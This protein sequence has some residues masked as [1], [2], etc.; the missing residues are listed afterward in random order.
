VLGG[1]SPRRRR[2]DPE[3]VAGSSAHYEDAAYYDQT[4]RERTSDVA[5]YVAC[6]RRLGKGG[7]LEVG[8]GSG[9][10]T[11]PMARAGVSVVAMDLSAT[12]LSALR[13]KLRAELPEVRARVEV[14]R[15]DMRQK[16]LGRRFS[17]II[18]PFNTFLHLYTRRDVERFLARVR[19]HLLPRGELCFDL[20]LPDAEEL[21][22]DPARPHF[23]PRFRYPGVGVVRYREHFDYDALRQVLFVSMEFMPKS[24]AAS[25]VTPLCHRQFFPQELEA[26]LHY[27][28][29]RIARA[30]G[31]WRGPPTSD[32]STLVLHCRVRSSAL[33]L[34]R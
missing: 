20:S 12:M 1:R 30:I 33:N 29:F 27:N 22:R 26:L 8:A 24:G 21:A 34:L 7:V 28:G 14:V 6:A 16:K 9:R 25:W 31:D 10:I 13:D 15:G 2:V 5:Y 23:A 11:L 32:T 18:C 19:E 4:Y 17:L 3:L